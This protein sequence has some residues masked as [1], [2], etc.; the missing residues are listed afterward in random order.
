[1]NAN[2]Y[3]WLALKGKEDAKGR[4]GGGRGK[5]RKESGGVGPFFSNFWGGK[6]KLKEKEEEEGRKK[7]GKREGEMNSA[8]TIAPN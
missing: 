2:T 6:E 7:K 3:G 1:V 8:I 4:E 5:K